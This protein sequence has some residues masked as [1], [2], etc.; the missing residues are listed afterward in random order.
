MIPTLTLGRDDEAGRSVRR[1]PESALHRPV[2]TTVHVDG[3]GGVG[4][5]GGP[6]AK[7]VQ[8]L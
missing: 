6:P 7:V 3:Q 5:A 4:P 2:P 8:N 1:G